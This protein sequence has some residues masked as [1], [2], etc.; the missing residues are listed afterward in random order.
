MASLANLVAEFGED[1]PYSGGLGRGFPFRGSRVPFL[2]Y[3]KG[4]YRAAVQR[5]PAALSIQTSARSPYDDEIL[6]DG[7][8]YAYRSGEIDQPDN[9]ALRAAHEL[10]VPLVYFIGTRPGWYKP[11]FPCYVREDHPTRRTV[12][13]TPGALVGPV[14]EPAPV[15]L[16]EEIERRYAV[17]QTRVRL[18]QARFRGRVVPAYSSQCAI[19]RLKELRLLDAAHIVGDIDE[20]GE[21]VV[22]NGLSLC[23]I[24][25]RAFDQNL[26]GVSPDYVVHV[27]RRLRDDEDG[28]MLDLLK[29]FHEAPL[30]LPSRASDCPDQ[31]RLGARFVR[32]LE[33]AG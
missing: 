11:V 31:A 20:R 14:D 13:V 27:S 25:H 17:R 21:P 28:P 29:G 2:N 30:H 26:V 24:H 23:S 15:P 33:L 4:I 32:F 1:I 9:R 12:L 16:E 8:L 22:T 5:G 10:Q 3:Q 18:H 19:C 7:F 6:A